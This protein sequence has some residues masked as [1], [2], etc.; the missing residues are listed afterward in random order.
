MLISIVDLAL[1]I[2]AENEDSGPRW[3]FCTFF[4]CS[5][6]ACTPQ[7]IM[8]SAHSYQPPT[9]AG[10][11]ASPPPLSTLHHSIPS[12]HHDD[13]PSAQQHWNNNHSAGRYS[14][15][16]APSRYDTSPH[17]GA[18]YSSLAPLP[19][20]LVAPDSSSSSSASLSQRYPHL[21]ARPLPSPPQY[22]HYAPHHQPSSQQQTYTLPLP[23]PSHPGPLPPMRL[24]PDAPLDPVYHASSSSSAL[25]RAYDPEQVRRRSWSYDSA[26]NSTPHGNGAGGAPHSNGHNASSSS[27]F[28]GLL[29]APVNGGGHS[30]GA[31]SPRGMQALSMAAAASSSSSSP[32]TT[33]GRS[34]QSVVAPLPLPPSQQQQQPPYQRQHEHQ[35]PATTSDSSDEGSLDGNGKK[36]RKRRRKATEEPRDLA[37]RKFTCASCG[38]MFARYVSPPSRLHTRLSGPLTSSVNPLTGRLA[39]ARWSRAR[40]SRSAE[41]EIQTLTPFALSLLFP[42][43][44]LFRPSALS[45]HEVRLLRSGSESPAPSTCN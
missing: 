42:F 26:G 29:G 24:R 25:R 4:S 39:T 34:L 5:S 45:T 22:Q 21:D 28:N 16:P 44:T 11:T 37:A 41:R 43:E 12:L 6:L 38:K 13:S 7:P 14:S 1:R 36:K 2:A 32:G 23:L 18:S 3:E 10:S 40:A 27:A 20:P 15:A 31:A 9:P 33:F 19:P 35:V 8:A 30:G 17:L